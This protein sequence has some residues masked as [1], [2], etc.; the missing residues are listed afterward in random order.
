MIETSF[1]KKMSKKMLSGLD[2]DRI[3]SE[4]ISLPVKILFLATNIP[5]WLVAISAAF[6]WL[7]LTL[8]GDLPQDVHVC[9]RPELYAVGGFLVA[10]SSTIMHGAQ[11]RLGDCLCCAHESRI[12]MFHDVTWQKRFKKI[13][14]GCAVSALL[15]CVYCRAW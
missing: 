10:A 12:E 6:D 2:A 11:L 1:F 4:A 15:A 3:L 9:G 13:D 14:V 7:S 8:N 5:Y